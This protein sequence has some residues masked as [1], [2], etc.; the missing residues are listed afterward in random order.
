MERPKRDGCESPGVSVRPI[1]GY[2][3][4]SSAALLA[5]VNATVGK[6]VLE[7]GDLNAFRLSEVRA[8]SAGFL[9]LVGIL[10]LRRGR[11][12]PRRG[13]L[14]FVVLFGLIGL[15][16]SQALYF[17]SIERLQ[18]GVAL[19]IVNLGIVLV[20][21]WARFRAGELVQRRLWLA[22]A[23]AFGGL[24]L[25]VQFWNGLALDAV[26]MGA[27]LACAFTYAAYIVLA[28]RGL[29][30]G[31]NASFLVGWGF[32]FAALLWAVVQPWWSFPF[33]A[34]ADD[35]SLLGRLAETTA[36]V[37]LL[38]SYVVTFGTVAPFVL[39]AA[40]LRHISPVQVVVVAALEPVF[41]SFV[42][43]IWLEEAL[44]G[45]ELA[46]GGLVL[47]GVIL[48]QTA[49]T[50]RRRPAEP[51]VSPSSSRRAERAAEEAV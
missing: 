17:I 42:A 27:A 3:F 50:S 11:L 5:A 32:C 31:L 22:V 44:G 8:T 26:G 14:A 13:E 10:L 39:Y 21:L 15:G 4:V 46:G 41:A 18:I 1:V 29:Q 25:V 33:G 6:I 47:A 37:W 34:V 49:R 9:L 30:R 23:L 20:A 7:S 35:V 16:L 51:Y 45:F 43:W 24:A 28:E 38:L 36:P 2:A 40:A 19:V 48:A 12:R